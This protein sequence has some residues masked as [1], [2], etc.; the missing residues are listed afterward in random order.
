[1]TRAVGRFLGHIWGAASKPVPE[2]KESQSQVV[3]HRVEETQGM[4]G[5]KKVV[6]RRTTI[7][8]IEVQEE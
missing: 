3:D 1:M 2:E 7:E 5:D 6:L 8:E 4:M